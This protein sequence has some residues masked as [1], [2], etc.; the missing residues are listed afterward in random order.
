VVLPARSAAA[1]VCSDAGLPSWLFWL[2]PLS[3]GLVC[4][5]GLGLDA[6]LLCGVPAERAC[7]L[8][9]SLLLLCLRRPSQLPLLAAAGCGRSAAL[10]HIAHGTGQQ[11]GLSG[12]TAPGR[13]HVTGPR[14]SSSSN[15]G[16]RG[17]TARRGRGG[18]RGCGHA[19]RCAAGVSGGGGS[20]GQGAWA[21]RS[22]QRGGACAANVRGA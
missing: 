19:L 20:G 7:V 2:Q 3:V 8:T 4:C 1:A 21:V 11:P 17:P 10:A 9:W 16:G 12:S 15:G 14:C 5:F 22:E 13:L 18:A 6:P